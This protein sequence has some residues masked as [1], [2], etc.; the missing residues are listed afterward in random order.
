MA[1]AAEVTIA[2]RTSKFKQRRFRELDDESE[3]MCVGL[4]RGNH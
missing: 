3:R 4:A 1:V 2:G